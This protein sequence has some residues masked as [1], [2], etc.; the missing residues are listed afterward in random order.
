MKA[1]GWYLMAFEGCA[2]RAVRISNGER[3]RDV[4]EESNADTHLTANDHY[5]GV[6]E[7]VTGGSVEDVGVS[8]AREVLAVYNEFMAE[9]CDP[10]RVVIQ[11]IV[12]HP[13]RQESHGDL[14]DYNTGSYLR[15]ATAGEQKAS[16]DAAESDG[17]AG[18]IEID[19]QSC[20]V[21]D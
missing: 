6:V 16:R 9:D 4:V 19:G 14:R 13:S 18:V 11:R 7:A 12:E 5:A 10:D 8:E 1:N 2:W 15:P 21:E 17:G 3:L 20:Y